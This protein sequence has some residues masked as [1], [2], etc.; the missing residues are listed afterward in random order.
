MKEKIS[1]I[2]RKAIK[3]SPL[4]TKQLQAKS[5]VSSTI[6][7]RIINGKNYTIDSLEKLSEALEIKIM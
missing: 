6:M 3:D 1:Q 5:G 2:I 4:S 7:Y